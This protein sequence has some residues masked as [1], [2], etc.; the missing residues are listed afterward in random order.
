VS[1]VGKTA[2]FFRI[3]NIRLHSEVLQVPIFN[4][5][6]AGESPEDFIESR[7]CRVNPLK[8]NL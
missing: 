1:N 7:N 3:Y 8:V 4:L 6:L 5:V 2:E